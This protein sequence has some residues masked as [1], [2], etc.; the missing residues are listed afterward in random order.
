[1]AA[2]ELKPGPNAVDISPNQDG[3]VI[4]EITTQA[5]AEEKAMPGDKVTVHYVGK[6]TDGSLFDSSRDRGE[7]FTFNLGKG[8]VIKGWDIG[9]ATMNV[10]ERCVLYIKSD[11]GYGPTGSPPK[12]PG[13][14]TLVFDVELFSFQG[15]DITKDKDQGAI[16]RTKKAGDGYDTPNDGSMVEIDLKGFLGGKQFDDRQLKFELGEGLDHQVPRG[17]QLCIE[18]MKIKET[19][20]VTLTPKYGFGSTGC[21]E[22]GVGP[23][24]T[25]KYEITLNSFEKSMESWQ[26][27]P[28]QKVVQAKMFKEKGTKFFKEGKFDIAASR[29]NRVI[30]FIEH[31]ISLK[32]DAEVER[33]NLLQAGRLN[34]ALCKMKVGDYLHTKNLCSKVIEENP[35][36]EKAWF[37]RGEA[38]FLLNDWENAKNDFEKAVE[39]DPENKAAKNKVALCEQKIKIHKQREK[40]TFANMF[41]KFAAIDQKREDAE[42]RRKPDTMNNIDEWDSGKKGMAASD[43]NNIEVVGDVDMSLDINQAIQEDQAQQ[44]KEEVNG[45]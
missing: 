13:G 12:I 17:A 3:G 42:K 1:M 23:N 28:D 29:Y 9:V 8:E 11:Y 2:T 38:G 30:D 20:E 22:K 24:E 41:D 37:R 39:L 4:K 31:E 15:E 36:N 16:K 35:E 5:S 43:P 27:D 33:K 32:G 18:K 21:K 19:A 45:H 14:A 10:G 40:K 7:K 34:L 26:L 44:E 6:L 25:L